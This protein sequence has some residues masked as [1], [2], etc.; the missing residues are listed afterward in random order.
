M[1][2]GKLNTKIFTTL[3]VFLL[4]IVFLFPAALSAQQRNVKFTHLTNLDGLSQSSVEAFLKDKHGYMWFG[5]QDGLNKYD[6]YKFTVYRYKLNDATSLRKSYIYSLYEDHVGNLWVGTNNGG[7][8]LYDRKHDSFIN[9]LA[10][11]ENPH[12]LSNN[13]ITSI[14]EDRRNNLWVGTY[15]NLN[16][17]NRKTGSV[18]RFLSDS[19]S[20]TSISNPSITCVFEDKKNNLWVGTQKGLNILNRKTGKCERFFNVVSDRNS[21][22]SN[23]ILNITEDALGNLW[24]GTD[25]GLNRYNHKT[26]SFKQYKQNPGNQNS[27]INNRVTGV[28]DAGNGGLWIG[29]ADG[30][31]FFNTRRGTFTHYKSINTDERSL[32]R[33]S[34]VNSMFYDKAGILWVCTSEGG[35]NIYDQNLSYLD[36]Y[37]NN[38]N[39]YETLSFNAVTGFAENKDGQIW[40]T[41]GGGALNLWNRKTNFFTHFNPDPANPNSLSIWGLLCVIQSKK[42]DYVWIG[43]YGKGLERFDLKTNTF[44]HYLSGKGEDQV[45]NE[46]IYSLFED[47]A[48]NIWMG[49][50]GGGVNVLNPATGRIK[51]YVSNFNLVNTIASNYVRAFCED[52]K[53]NIWIGTTNGLSK[54]NVRTQQITRFDPNFTK[55]ASNLI[56]AL[57]VDNKN[58][59]I[60]VGT[61]GGGIS[62]LDLKTQKVVSYS[63]SSGLSNNTINSI[64]ADGLNNIWLSTNNGI[65][66][67]NLKTKKFKNYSLSNGLQSFAFS[68]GA[69]LRAEN[70]DIF[71]GGENGFNA[72]NPAT[73][74]ENKVIPPV[75]I[76]DFQLFNKQVLVGSKD[77][78]L[79]EQISETKEITLNYDQSVITFEYTA[80]NFTASSQN[81]YAYTL[82]NFD[83]GWNYVGS[84]RKATYTNLDPGEY[85]FKVKAAN[86][87]GLWNTKGTT[88]KLI[89]L[90]PYWMTW[91]FRVIVFLFITTIIY[92]VYHFRIRSIKAQKILLEKQVQARTREVLL[93]TKSLEQVN[94]ELLKTNADLDSFVYSAS[95]DLRAP[96]TSIL[97]LVNLVKIKVNQTEILQL[98]GLM[99][100]CV[101]SLDTFIKDIIDFSRNSRTE[102]EYDTIDFDHVISRSIDQLKFMEEAH[103]IKISYSIEGDTEFISDQKRIAIIVNN[104]LSNAIKYSDP[105]KSNSQINIRV[106]KHKGYAE[107]EVKDNGLGVSPENVTKIFDMFYRAASQKTGA[108]LGLYIVQQI[109]TKLNGTVKVHSIQGQET[110]FLIHIPE[111]KEEPVLI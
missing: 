51:K 48:G 69:G 98:L 95:H 76:T 78:P 31:D 33:T 43:T 99:E 32:A 100:V 68:G 83:K 67:L 96:L 62:E 50:N 9:Y 86:N 19:A 38:P 84:A 90:P 14:Y 47:R 85:Y 60:W 58:N 102:I 6:G 66:K 87:D 55:L 53:G 10:E 63:E 12:K 37:R 36:L 22:S 105:A 3:R 52:K 18:T 54:Y 110:F 81:Q 39:N 15:Y 80:L 11:P 71:F 79:K 16:L 57:Y 4:S 17:F 2:C 107:L 29:T 94:K 56:S 30:L 97:G 8:S 40:I 49:T 61:R 93:Q 7:L 34:S 21:V 88:L 89:I 104:L 64:I 70:G 91:W 109:L 28:E 23:N 82:V 77:S 35:I 74:P 92:A 111:Y 72:F 101:H 5:T 75:L 108:G 73:L 106:T 20:N 25:N 13:S 27:L 26:K 45:N 41:T 1:R 44:K 42:N 59:K 46:A 24:V 65:S 103:Q